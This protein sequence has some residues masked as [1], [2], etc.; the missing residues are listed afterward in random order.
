[1][2]TLSILPPAIQTYVRDFDARS[3]RLALLG[4]VGIALSFF[5]IWLVICCAIDRLAHFPASVRA[6][7]LAAG[8]VGAIAILWRPLR[9]SRH[10]GVNWVRAAIR[11]EQYDPQF[12][13]RLITVASRVLG[14]AEHRGSDDMLRELVRDVDRRASG[15]DPAKLLPLRRIASPW[16]ALL[17]TILVF[18]G[19]TQIQGLQM[20]T[21]AARFLTPWADILPVTTTQISVPTGNRDVVQS[22]SLR[23]E[24]DVKRLDR[25]SAVSL[26][27]SEDGGERWSRSTMDPLT[28][29]GTGYAFTLAAIDRDLLYRISAGDATSRTYAL[30]V[31]RAP[32]V[33]RF[34]IRY[35][36]PPH[37]GRQPLSIE[38]T[39]GQIE[40]PIGTRIVLTV[41]ATEPL[42]HALLKIAGEKILMQPADGSKGNTAQAS[43]VRRA[44]FSIKRDGPYSLDLISD[45]Q[46]PGEGPTSTMRIRAIPDNRPLAI[47]RQAGDSLRLHPRDIV[48]LG[49]QAI[50]DYGLARLSLSVQVNSS[51]AVDRRIEIQG[52][53]RRQDRESELDLGTLQLGIGDVVTVTLHAV[54]RGGQTSTSEPVLILI[55]PRSVDAA[56]YQRIAELNTAATQ[57]ATLHDQLTQASAA[58]E[59]AD[60]ESATRSLAYLAARFRANRQL[61][62]AAET[63][64]LMRQALFRVLVTARS[65]E[66]ANALSAWIDQAQT[67]AWLAEDLFRRADAPAGMGSESRGMLARSL[68]L[69][70]VLHE[71]LKAVA[72]GERAR[73]LTADRENL[74][75]S[76]QKAAATTQPADVKQRLD[77][78]LQR[79]RDD[80]A[81]GAKEIGLDPAAADFDVQLKSRA[82]SSSAA[83][84]GR[85]PADFVS[86]AK[87]WVQLLQ[88]DRTQP[89][90]LDERLAVAAQAEAVRGDAD[91]IRARDLHLAARAAANIESSAQADPAARVM[92]A[93]TFDEYAAALTA[94]LRED[95]LAR[96]QTAPPTPEEVKAIGDAA[97]KG[98][99]TLQ[100]FAASVEFADSTENASVERNAEIEKLAMQASAETAARNFAKAAELDAAMAAKLAGA[101]SPATTQTTQPSTTSTT[102]STTAPTAGE[103]RAIAQTVERAA[104]IDQL[105]GVQQRIAGEIAATQN[106]PLPD[107]AG[108]Q[109]DVASAI[110][111]VNQSTDELPEKIWTDT[112]MA[113]DPNWRG[114]ATAAVLAAQ[115][116][117]AAMPQQI[118]AMQEALPAWRE[119][120][121][122]AEQAKRDAAAMPDQQ[123]QPAAERTAA[124]AE[125]D[126]ADAAKRFQERRKPVSP[127]VARKLLENL[128]PFAPDTSDACKAIDLVLLPALKRIEDAANAGVVADVSRAADEARQ[129]I[130]AVQKELTIAQDTMMARDPL[131]AAKWSARAAADSLD[132]TPPDLRSAQLRQRD[133]MA[134]L[135][136]AL[137]REIHDAASMRMAMV[138]AMQSVYAA[139]PQMPDIPKPATATTNASNPA[140]AAKAATEALLRPGL[141]AVR[142]WARVRPQASRSFGSAMRESDPAGY[143]E[144]LRLYF[145]ALGK[146]RT[147]SP[148]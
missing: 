147:E 72:A 35:D 84:R 130:D 126:T 86:A 133:T 2:S 54:D 16:I 38:N 7:L 102:A 127:D 40:A 79:A 141:T 134:A 22:A 14:A 114:R 121:A 100:R 69:T 142:E 39:D 124:Q 144:P 28:P 148:K 11:I 70:R 112:A 80:I 51:T 97:S 103:Q 25:D 24:A 49:F 117:L 48:P 71:E 65:P 88:R 89:L 125:R 139:G 31:R 90:V 29:G 53:P 18:I 110:A 12:G 119:A 21:L 138:P 101:D 37:T 135:S 123:R 6:G 95:D 5:G 137:D 96:P 57:A 143:E 52:D 98:R 76:E 13:Q 108:R 42:D 20:Q 74:V 59:E 77:Q 128:S 34:A 19:L 85:A 10:R 118:A 26:F 15:E 120:A 146:R 92:P 67:Q 60:R 66:L 45:R 58:L 44:T 113:D 36:Y 91:L 109:R 68:D 136:R 46:V 81:A 55:S 104:T 17:T 47:L 3:R 115:E 56:T 116:S 93:T 43:R 1:M 50:D 105:G 111:R 4:G 94:V 78:T 132:R 8:I 87:E 140:Q 107:L 32:A 75:A 41:T 30:R 73:A 131:M 64:S 145:E 83:L 61:S 63:A 82:D 99:A 62:G 122:R 27:I 23:I 33:E 106:A 9:A 129:S